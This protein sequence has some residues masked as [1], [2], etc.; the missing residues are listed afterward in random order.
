[1]NVGVQVC[2]EEVVDIDEEVV[3]FII[4]LDEEMEV[5]EVLAFDI[6]NEAEIALTP[7]R[8]EQPLDI[9]VVEHGTGYVGIDGDTVLSGR[10]KMLIIR[11]GYLIPTE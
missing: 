2:A 1:M 8:H 3:V 9:H 6:I 4:V 7:S 11:L 5:L 10:V